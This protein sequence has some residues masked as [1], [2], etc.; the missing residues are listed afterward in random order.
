[1]GFDIDGTLMP[2]VQILVSFDLRVGLPDLHIIVFYFL[3]AHDAKFFF[4]LI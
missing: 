2:K 1:M 3:I 4:F